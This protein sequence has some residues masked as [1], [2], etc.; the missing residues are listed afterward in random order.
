M[1]NTLIVYKKNGAFIQ[2]VLNGVDT[3]MPETE[4]R[5]AQRY[6]SIIFDQSFD[7]EY[8]YE[9]VTAYEYLDTDIG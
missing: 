7:T 3:F 5:E 9:R 8:A 1:K 4:I 2:T 6:G